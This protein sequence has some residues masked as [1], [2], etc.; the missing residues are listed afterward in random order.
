MMKSIQELQK[1]RNVNSLT[2]ANL[3]GISPSSYSDKRNGR[4]KFQPMEIVILC[5]YFD[6]KVEEV[7]DFFTKDTRKANM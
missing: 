4:R 6:V 2:L 3:L 5:Q 7:K 1:E